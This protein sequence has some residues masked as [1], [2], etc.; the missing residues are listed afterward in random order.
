MKMAT[1]FNSDPGLLPEVDD[2]E[3]LNNVTFGA[4]KAWFTATNSNLVSQL[5]QKLNA[6]I[7]NIKQDLEAT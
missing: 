4:L 1:N 6:D 5:E 7:V 2:N 3:T